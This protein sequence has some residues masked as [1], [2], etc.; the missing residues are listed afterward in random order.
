MPPIGRQEHPPAHD[1][2]RP[3][4]PASVKTASMAL[5]PDRQPDDEAERPV[6]V[7]DR[8]ACVGSWWER[9][10]RHH[11]WAISCSTRSSTLLERVLAQHGAL[12]LVV[13]LQ[14]HPVHRVVA[15][16]RLGLADELAAELGP[17]GL[18][19]LAHGPVDLARRCTTRSTFPAF[20][21]R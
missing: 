21:I 18:R 19:R 20:S 15:A 14:V 3:N 1:V 8:V 7:L 5:H 4:H 2:G 11:M 16:L 12:G 6:V 17:R 9:L 10:A 13:Q